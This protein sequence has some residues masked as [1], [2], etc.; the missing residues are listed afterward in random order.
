MSMFHWVEVSME[1]GDAN[2]AEQKLSDKTMHLCY[3]N[4]NDTYI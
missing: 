4:K 3:L 2:I 1:R